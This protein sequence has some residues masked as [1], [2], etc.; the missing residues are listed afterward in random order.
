M[1]KLLRNID[2]NFWQLLNAVLHRNTTNPSAPV[3]GQIW[4]NNTTK[5]PKFYDGTAVVDLSTSGDSAEL[6]GEPG[7]YYLARA[8]HT[9]V[10]TISTVTGLQAAIDSKPNK[11][12]ALVGDGA[13]TSIVIARATHLCAAAM[14]NLVQVQLAATGAIQDETVVTAA[15]AGSGD[16]TLTFASAPASNAM[17][18]TIVG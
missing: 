8:N 6:G 12:S 9:G 14:P 11:Y 13:A 7:S 16:V 15:V 5:T 4:Y 18:V 3:E 10:Q 2:Q 17:R 1:K